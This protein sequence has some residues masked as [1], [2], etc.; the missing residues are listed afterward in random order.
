M[1]IVVRLPLALVFLFI[2]TASSRA[3]ILNLN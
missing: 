3:N 1:E 2:N